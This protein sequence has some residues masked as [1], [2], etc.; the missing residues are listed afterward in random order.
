MNQSLKERLKENLPFSAKFLLKR[1]LVASVGAIVRLAASAVRFKNRLL[2]AAVKH[3]L[4]L[5]RAWNVTPRDRAGAQQSQPPPFGASD[6]LFLTNMIAGASAKSAASVERP[7][8]ASII[9]PVFN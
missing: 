5:E 3:G 9:I 7:V 1:L 8:R 4:D 2:D 6:F